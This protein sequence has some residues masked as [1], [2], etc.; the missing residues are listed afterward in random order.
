MHEW[1]L[2]QAVIDS[3]IA[4][5]EKKGTNAAKEIVLSIGEL[6]N[7]DM[8]I[9]DFS[10]KELSKGTNLEN[11]T[12]TYKE[13]KAILVCNKCGCE[14]SYDKSFEKLT[15]EEKEAIHF[16]PETLHIYVHCPRCNSV[17]FDVKEGRGIF[18]KDVK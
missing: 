8:Q 12:I 2:A 9:F 1:A 14:W 4:L 6:Q 17:D 5:L 15:E 11:A 16:I 10:L 18:I 7:I 13:E 3:T